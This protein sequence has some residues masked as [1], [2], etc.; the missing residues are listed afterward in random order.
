V[1]TAPDRVGHRPIPVSIDNAGDWDEIARQIAAE[2]GLP[3]V[4]T[5]QIVVGMVAGA[6]PL[7]FEADAARNMNLL[8]GTFADGVIAQCQRNAG[9]LHGEQPIAAIVNLIGVRP[10]NGPA[11][12]RVHL[13]I[14]LRDAA[15]DRE[16]SSQFWDLE[17]GAEVTVG[18]SQC[19][20]CG[21]PIATGELICGYCATDVR[22]I[23]GAP[24]VVSRLELY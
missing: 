9:C 16:V 2:S 7:L 6:V 18:Q 4:L 13:T 8:R 22:T 19:P 11:A 20:N 14:R 15:G 5:P 10:V 3:T 1:S 23:V 24:L 17:V 21:A 12:L